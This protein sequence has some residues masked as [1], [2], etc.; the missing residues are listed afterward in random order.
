MDLALLTKV[1]ISSVLSSGTCYN[2][3]CPGLQ[4]RWSEMCSSIFCTGLGSPG[5][6]IWVLP[7]NKDWLLVKSGYSRNVYCLQWTTCCIHVV[8]SQ[9]R[10]CSS[11]YSWLTTQHIIT[12]F[13]LDFF[14]FSWHGVSL[15]SLAH[16]NTT[17]GE[18]SQPSPFCSH[19]LW[20]ALELS[21]HSSVSATVFCC[22]LLIKF[23]PLPPG[24]YFYSLPFLRF[25]SSAFLENFKNSI[26][27]FLR[28]SHHTIWNWVLS[29]L[30][31]CITCYT[32]RP[33]LKQ[34]YVSKYKLV[35]AYALNAIFWVILMPGW[36]T[37]VNTFFIC[38]LQWI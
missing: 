38:Q 2:L 34:K 11:I 25:S 23:G 12:S 15:S 29:D 24:L 27:Y 7:L 13:Y 32:S 3:E 22:F 1:Q 6:N 20:S 30:Y 18:I 17:E 10:L 19:R 5:C 28:R 36:H 16:S 33:H 8:Q 26:L 31:N 21:N 4:G 9:I 35:N 14:F 37:N